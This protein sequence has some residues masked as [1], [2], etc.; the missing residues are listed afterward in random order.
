[1]PDLID[2]VDEELRRERAEKLWQRYGIYAVGA[3]TAIVLAVAGWQGWQW[4]D[5]RER[6]A[7]ARAFLVAAEQAVGEKPQAIN[8]FAA[9]AQNGRAG[10]RLLARFQEAR[11]KAE[12]GD[13]AGAIAVWDAV[14]ADASQDRLY[15]DFASLS[16]V[17]HQIDGGDPAMLEARLAPLAA[18]ESPWRYSAIELQAL[19][20]ERRGN[21]AQAATLFRQLAEDAAAPPQIRARARDLVMALGS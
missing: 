16:S 7:Q 14:A 19:L 10:Y 2:E 5:A 13:L 15:R 1:M 6:E 9:L 11:L 3:A 4:Y 12:L 17:I 21:R 8:A 18:A 20:A